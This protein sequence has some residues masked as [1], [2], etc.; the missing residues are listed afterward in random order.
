MFVVEMCDSLDWVDVGAD[1][2]D[3][4]RILEVGLYFFPKGVFL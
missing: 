1:V 3:A 4:V 2:M